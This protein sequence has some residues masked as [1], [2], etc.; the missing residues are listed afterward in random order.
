MQFVSTRGG[1]TVSLDEA[2]VNGIA[3]DGGLYVPIELPS[4]SP[5]DFGPAS[6][7]PEVAAV[8]LQPFFTGSSLAGELGQIL[9]PYF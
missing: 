1:E 7:S 4:F 5:D 8:L 2:L 3:A 9:D 6:T